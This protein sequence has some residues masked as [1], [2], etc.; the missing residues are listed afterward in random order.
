[1]IIVLMNSNDKVMI[2]DSN[3]VMIIIMINEIIMKCEINV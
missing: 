1:M 3:D 2:N